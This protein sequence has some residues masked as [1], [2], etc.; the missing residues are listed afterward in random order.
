MTVEPDDKAKIAYMTEAVANNEA[1]FEDREDLDPDLEAA[2]SWA[3]DRTPAQIMADRDAT[4]KAVSQFATELAYESKLWCACLLFAWG[5]LQGCMG[6]C[7]CRRK[8]MAD[9]EVARISA[10]VHGPLLLALAKR[11]NYH[12]LSVVDLFQNGAP[13]IG[14]MER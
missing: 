4:W 13:L 14:R 12:D 5:V 2:I 10:G 9:H 1:E 6:M 3:A 8:G 11:A 7:V